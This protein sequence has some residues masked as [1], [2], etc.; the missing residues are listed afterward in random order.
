MGCYERVI[1]VLSH[2]ILF[3]LFFIRTTSFDLLKTIKTLPDI[4]SAV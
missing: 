1:T 4:E 2:S 3:E